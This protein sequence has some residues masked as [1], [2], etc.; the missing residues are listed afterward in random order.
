MYLAKPFFMIL[1]SAT[2]G[3]YLL[4]ITRAPYALRQPEILTTGDTA[5][6]VE[7]DWVGVVCR[8]LFDFRDGYCLAK[9]AC[10]LCFPDFWIDKVSGL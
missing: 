7:T 8:V 1:V 2:I 6:Y 3:G 10:A 5:P 4:V 9:S